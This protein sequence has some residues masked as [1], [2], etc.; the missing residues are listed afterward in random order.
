MAG[1]ISE[2]TRRHCCY[3]YSIQYGIHNLIAANLVE[4]CISLLDLSRPLRTCARRGQI[5]RLRGVG[6][7]GT[8]WPRTLNTSRM[9]FAAIERIED[10]IYSHF[11]LQKN[12]S[13]HETHLSFLFLKPVGTG[14]VTCL[15]GAR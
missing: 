13:S 6:S 8:D 5:R 1:S 2:C 12:D 3:T 4:I 11:R 14:R 7:S 15:P 10:H 9:I